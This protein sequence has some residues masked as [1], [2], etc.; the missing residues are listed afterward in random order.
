MSGTEVEKPEV[1]E[2][3]PPDPASLEGAPTSADPP[4]A[5]ES[6]PDPFAEE[7]TGL[8]QALQQEQAAREAV[9]AELES[10]K[11]QTGTLQ[12]QYDEALAQTAAAQQ[13]RDTAE[14]YLEQVRG[15]VDEFARREQEAAI[16]EAHSEAL[17]NH[18]AEAQRQGR[19]IDDVMAS[20][21]TVE[22]VRSQMELQFTRQE[23]A[24][25]KDMLRAQATPQEIAQQVQEA[26]LAG[27][28]Q[29]I[30]DFRGEELR[31]EQQAK[32][33]ARQTQAETEWK[34]LLSEIPQL[35]PQE[36][37]FVD[38]FVK[39]PNLKTVSDVLPGLV[40]QFRAL[41]VA[42]QA[43]ADGTPAS[44]PGHAASGGDGRGGGT[45]AEPF[46]G[47]IAEAIAA[48]RARAAS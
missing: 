29:K 32:Q 37:V 27:F 13:W 6:I 35:A 2:V 5:E 4:P 20:L 43:S 23:L 40:G 16:Q 30:G 41:Q 42:R 3:T 45:Q 12:T 34:A 8:T 17:R 26:T 18:L 46:K 9:A 31:L 38:G 25:L 11:G 7:R 44:I 36:K 1:E 21:P 47:G 15:K 28:D 39:N 19:P 24:E 33:A 14:P 22:S 10:L 48:V